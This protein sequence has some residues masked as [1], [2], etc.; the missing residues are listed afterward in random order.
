MRYRTTSLIALMGISMLSQATHIL[1][2]EMFYTHVGN[3]DY[4][5]TLK[6][7][8]DCGPGNT[9]GTGFDASAEFAVYDANG[10]WLFSEFS[11]LG[12][13]V[14]VPV[15]LNNPCLQVLP[16]VCVEAAEYVAVL[17][18]PPIAGGYNITYQRCCR[19]PTIL[20]LA[21]PDQ[22]GITCAV[23]VPDA[24]I[25]GVNSSPAFT[26]LPP[27]ALCSSDPFSFD[28][29]A[30]DADGDVLVY[31]LVQPWNGGSQFDPMPSPPPPPPFVDVP[32]AAGFST[33]NVMGTAPPLS[34]DASTGMMSTL[35]N[36]L[37]QYVYS[38]RVQEFRNGALMTEVRRDFRFEVVPCQL[39]VFSAIQTQQ[40]FCSGFTVDFTNQSTNGTIF[41][42]DFGDPNATNDTSNVS[43][44]TWTYADT[45]TYTIT[46]IAQPGW[47]CADTATAVF[48]V[49]APINPSFVAPPP[50]CMQALPVQLDAL[51]MF[52]PNADVEWDLGP[53]AIQPIMQGDPISADF[54]APGNYAVELT[55]VGNGC[56]ESYTDTV[57]LYPEPVA[58]F[59]PD[60]SGCVPLPVQFSN[61]STAWTPM[62]YA[63]DFGDGNTSNA[64]TPVHDYQIDG[65]FDVSLK[66]MTSSGCIDTV[67]SV[68]AAAVRTYPQPV[69]GFTVYPPSVNIM[70]PVVLVSDQSEQ[71]VQWTYWVD[72]QQV[73][74]PTFLW[75][76]S[77]A[78]DYTI[79]QVVST[80]NTCTDE[81]TAVVHVRDHLFYAPN[82]F[83]PD[84]DGV[85][86][87]FLPHVI[88]A[89][90]YELLV[91]DRWGSIL[92]RT[93]ETKQGWEGRNSPPEVYSY[94][95]TVVDHGGHAQEYFG[96]VTLVR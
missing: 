71:A 78:G 28:H 9:N 57:R 95:A 64:S 66:V 44:P 75:T 92:F 94:K 82:A 4:E 25:W 85:N 60:T 55:I 18:L 65:V 11:S 73:T 22:F 27:I 70:D 2:G 3:D 46:L 76:F 68:H 88:G 93:S 81:A 26:A 90:N 80:S 63:W 56:T 43:N 89:V 40:G 59:A 13:T 1:G 96:S 91:F 34:I 8:R 50:M 37:G 61:A 35:P 21:T 51:G 54:N 67:E 72:G 39:S 16:I 23:F 29:S 74:D 62:Q 58:S 24:S 47:P 15:V 12:N 87:I 42:W 5:V 10:A 79:T 83:T 7:Y 77:D 41:H 30:V 38:V 86:E 52:G 49:F 69:A 31:S 19:T 36:L 53:N 84:G 48:Q 17:N 6:I 32:W 20:N 33:A 45:G 14:L